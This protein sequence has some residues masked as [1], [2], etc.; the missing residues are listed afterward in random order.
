MAD[1]NHSGFSRKMRGEYALSTTHSKMSKS[2]GKL[3][4]IHIYH[5]KDILQLTCTNYGPGNYSDECTAL[6]DFGSNYS[7]VRPT[8]YQRQETTIK[9]TYGRQQ[10]NNAIVQ[11]AVDDIFLQD[12]DKL[13]VEDET[14]KNIDGEVDEDELYNLEQMVFDEK[15]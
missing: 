8:K 1:A 11:H 6:G 15:E 12:K 5:P 2:T 7:K 3:R 14:H 13:S 10:E 4:K 9:K